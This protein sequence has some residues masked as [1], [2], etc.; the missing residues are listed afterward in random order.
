[1]KQCSDLIQSDGRYNPGAPT[2]HNEEI[3]TSTSVHLDAVRGL[4]ALAVMTVAGAMELFM[5]FFSGVKRYHRTF[6]LSGL[7]TVMAYRLS[8]KQK[9]IAAHPK[10]VPFPVYMRL[11]T[12]DVYAYQEVLLGGEYEFALPFSPT[13]IVDVGANIGIRMTTYRQSM[14]LFG[15]GM[16]RSRSLRLIQSGRVTT[17]HLQRTKE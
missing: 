2:S 11:R 5:T 13:T 9:E 12:T 4:A 14:R 8:G 16:E 1:M 15:I 7:I 10:G 17:G 3:T 6:G